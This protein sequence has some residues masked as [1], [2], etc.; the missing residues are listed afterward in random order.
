MMIIRNCSLGMLALMLVTSIVEAAPTPAQRCEGAIEVAAGKYMQCRLQAESKFSISLDSSKRTEE[1]DKCSRRLGQAFASARAK[2]GTLNC[3]SASSYEYQFL[4]SQWS[5]DAAAW[6]PVGAPRFVDNGDGTVFDRITSLVWEK[7]TTVVG[8]GPNLADPH[9]VDNQYTWGTT[10][11]PFLA[12]GTVFTDFLGKLNGVDGSPCF[13]GKCDWR[14]PTADELI[15]VGG[16]A[17]PCVDSVLGPSVAA[18]GS[19]NSHSS[20]SEIL[21]VIAYSVVW[22]GLALKSDPLGYRAVRSGL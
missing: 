3:T 18:Y 14:L 15:S 19:A 10:T 7:K 4:L 9:D 6:A 1:F 2:F 12:N 8:S 13:T 20:G 5:D 22:P 16:C 21:P 11:P 17:L